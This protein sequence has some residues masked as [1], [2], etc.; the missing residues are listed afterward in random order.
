MPTSPGRPRAIFW[1]ILPI[2]L[3]VLWIALRSPFALLGLLL[4]GVVPL[5]VIHVTGVVVATLGTL[6]VHVKMWH[7]LKPTATSGPAES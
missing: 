2:T 5:A 7:A 3:P 4:A 6:A 1:F